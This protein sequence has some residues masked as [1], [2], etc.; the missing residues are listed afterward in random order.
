MQRRMP[1]ALGLPRSCRRREGLL[2]GLLLLARLGLG[3]LLLG[4]LLLGLGLRGFRGLVL[5]ALLVLALRL[6]LRAEQL[7]DRHL[8]PVAPPGAEAEDARVAARARRVARAQAVE[9]L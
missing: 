1:R 8:R 3:F 6:V 5:L 9:E 4:F 2:G 7:D